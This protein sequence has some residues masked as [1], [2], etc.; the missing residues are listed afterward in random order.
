MTENALLKRI[1][2]KLAHDGWRIKKLRRP[3]WEWGTWIKYRVVDA[4]NLGVNFAEEGGLD[5][6]A[7]EL[8]VLQ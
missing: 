4:N 3:A 6:L 2:R 8:G 1:A 5:V 7:H